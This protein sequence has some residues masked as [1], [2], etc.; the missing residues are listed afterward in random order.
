MGKQNSPWR[1]PQR[2][3]K[4]SPPAM[5]WGAP[6]ALGGRG[7]MGNDKPKQIGAVPVLF[8]G[9][10]TRLPRWGQGRCIWHGIGRRVKAII[11]EAG[12]FAPEFNT[13][14]IDDGIAMGHGGMLYSLP[15]RE[16]I[17]DSVEY[18][19]NAHQVDAM[20]CISNCDKINSGNAHGC[21]AAQHPCHLR[22]PA[23]P[24]RLAVWTGAASTLSTPWLW[25]G[26][27]RS[28]T[29]NL[30]RWRRRLSYLRVLFR[31]VYRQLHELPHR[32]PGPG[33]AGAMAPY[34]PPMLTVWPSLT[35]RR[36]ASLPCAR[37]W[38]GQGDASVLP[39]SIACQASVPQWPWPWILPWAVPPIP[40]LHLVGPLPREAGG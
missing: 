33:P 31:H 17:A 40:V 34:W 39:R 16:L 2:P 9:G 24:W 7:Q 12:C 32:G 8:P 3:F 20:V 18:M 27:S 26:T 5:A 29:R 21:D 6:G 23:V 25:P 15:S 28:L 22:S 19:C 10:P 30:R 4:G 37:H 13:I 14:A 36:G 38:Y 35:R 11:E 1:K